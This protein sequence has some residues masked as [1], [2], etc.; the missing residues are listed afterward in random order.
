VKATYN[1]AAEEET[2]EGKVDPKIWPEYHFAGFEELAEHEFPNA[3]P[4]I[5][6]S[7]NSHLALGSLLIA[8]GSDG[9]GKSTWT[10]DGAAHL[11]AG[12]DWLGLPVPRAVRCL[13]IENEGPGGLFQAKLKRKCETWDG[14]DFR[15]NIHTYISPWGDFSFAEEHARKALTSYCDEYGI[16]VVMANPTLGLGVGPSGKP[17]ETKQFVD[18]LREC[19]LGSSR[20]FWLLHHENKSGQIS[21]DWGRHPD[22]KVLLQAEGNQQRTK[23]TWEKT[24]WATLEPSQKALMLDWVIETQGYTVTTLD[25]VG[26]SDELLVQRLTEYLTEH[27]G[28]ATKHVCEGVEGTDSRLSKLLKERP[29]FDFFDGPHAAKCWIVTQTSAEEKRA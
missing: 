14:E 5:G 20:A 29:E 26:A 13:L 23:L 28:T 24:R 6:D 3:E 16:E 4:L 11:C 8:Y 27:P 25:T 12:R 15:A 10:L 17:D 18:W 22:T 21:G 9:A 1:S 2:F 19:G 7:E